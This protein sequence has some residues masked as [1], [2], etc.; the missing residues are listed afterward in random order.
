MRL[1]GAAAELVPTRLGR[2]VVARIMVFLTPLA[3]GTVFLVGSAASSRTGSAV[4]ARTEI[5][6]KQFAVGAAALLGSVAHAQSVDFARP[7]D[8]IRLTHDVPS[9]SALTVEVRILITGECQPGYAN[10]IW[11]EQKNSLEHKELTVCRSGVSFYLAGAT[12]IVSTDEVPVGRWVHVACQQAGGVARIW[13]DGS[14]VT[15]A[16][17]TSNPIPSVAGS[18]NSIGAGLQNDLQVVPGAIC[19]I[20]WIRVSTCARYT[21]TSFT[22]PSECDLLPA[23]SC[24]ALLFTFAESSAESELRN[25]GYLTGTATIGAAWLAGATA[26]T[27]TASGD[28]AD[29]DGTPDGCETPPCPGDADSSGSIDGVDLAIVLQNW[30][31]PSAKYPGADINA[32]GE[33]N[34]S[35]LAIVLAGWGACP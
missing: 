20:D 28:D 18:S 34:G 23:D 6:M 2:V 15:E 35:D 30:G 14:L 19:R 31:A 25:L 7:T 12:D 16:A 13:I 22:P 11:R 10:A 26:P 1:G 29:A 8:T 4:V 32:D 33:V 5:E 3:I 24:T 17:T 21:T 9:T 27:L